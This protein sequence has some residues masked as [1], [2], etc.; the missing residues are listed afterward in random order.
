MARFPGLLYTGLGLVGV[1]VLFYILSVGGIL[2]GGASA[3]NDL[4]VYAVT[5]TLLMLGLGTFLL[6]WAKMN[7]PGPTP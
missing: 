7:E 1:A 3:Y 5:V 4:G 2:F 6:R